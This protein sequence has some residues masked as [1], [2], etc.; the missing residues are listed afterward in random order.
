MTWYYNDMPVEEIDSKY[1]GF[2]YLITNLVTGKR[3]IGKK[4]SKFSKTTTKTVTLKSGVKKKKKV[5]SKTDSDWKTYWSSSK[6][7]QA[8]V[9]ALGENKFRR[10]ILMFCLTKG[11][12]TYYEAKFQFKHEVLEKPDEWYNGQIQCRIHRSHIKNEN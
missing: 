2:V 4:L 3:Y 11:T 12:A 7:V 6:D 10:E 1:V 5:R 8:D 9:N